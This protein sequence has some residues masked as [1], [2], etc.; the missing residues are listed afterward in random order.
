[1]PKE[2]ID[3]LQFR[4]IIYNA[5]ADDNLKRLRVFLK[6]TRSRKWIDQCLNNTEK[7]NLPLVVAASEGNLDVVEFLIR[8]GADPNVRG[9]VSIEGETIESATPLWVAAAQGR[10]NVVR[11]LVSEAGADINLATSTS[12]TPLR[13][14][15]YDGH[16]SIVK[17]LVENGADIETPNRLGHTPLM[18]ASF[19]GK[20]SVVRYL[21][22]KG[23]SI[24]QRSFKGNTALHDA[25]EGDHAEVCEVLLE[26]GATM[27]KDDLGLC[28]LLCSALY[29]NGNVLPVLL[30]YCKSNILRRDALKL[31]G[32][33][34]CDKKMNV[35]GAIT[36]WKEAANVKLTPEEEIEMRGI[37]DK[38]EISKV[39]ETD[40]E[41]DTQEDVEAI[42]GHLDA[43]YMQSLIMRER[44]IGPAHMD[45][46]YFLRYRGA[47]YCDTL[48]S[49]RCFELWLHALTL[50]QKYLPPL[51]ICTVA[52][53]EAYQE[54]FSLALNEQ[55][56]NLDNGRWSV[57]AEQVTELYDRVC[58]ELERASRE[59]D[60]AA[61][62]KVQQLEYDPEK[63]KI[64]LV[65]ITLQILFMIY[66]LSLPLHHPQNRGENAG[67]L[68]QITEVFVD[69]KRFV[70]VCEKL[71]VLPLHLALTDNENRDSVDM[72]CNYVIERLIEGGVDISAQN[73]DG[74]TPLHLLLLHIK[75]RESIVHTL[76]NS[77]A[78]IL[79]R[80][81]EDNT[82]L[83]L[84]EL[85][86]LKTIQSGKYLTLAGLASNVVMRT[87]AATM[88]TKE[89][90]DNYIDTS[91]LIPYQIRDFVKRH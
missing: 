21:L 29:G 3:G 43:I 52:T 11:F 42:Q 25:A 89:A 50:Q 13:S 72:P 65:L 10:E 81:K 70:R 60:F 5:A 4:S 56:N 75:P 39:Y 32:C 69:V 68:R 73:E 16:L 71:K 51:N 2:Y 64:N 15:C 6:P 12:S 55:A 45:V 62:Q 46:H 77:G 26:Y 35:L 54:T 87:L 23:A 24:T 37:Y 79:A 41:I 47:I 61:I 18:I 8:I 7:K 83:D 36:L 58:Y 33:T 53:L 74:N 1:M 57:Q 90:V 19:K 84:V 22:S 59:T 91:N 27:E 67:T 44:I 85:S 14:A 31:F 9:N 17:F 66:R 38:H 86:L 63:E 48:R 76:L 20:T 49:K 82:C 80:N 30:K 40:N 34:K 28:P 88:K 78:P